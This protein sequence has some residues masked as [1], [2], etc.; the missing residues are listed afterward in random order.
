MHK[1]NDGL[2]LL[3]ILSAIQIPILHVIGQGGLLG[4]G[5]GHIDVIWFL[6][7]ASMCAV[8]CFAMLS[9]Y[10]D[11]GRHWRWS[12][13]LR[14]HL[15]V[16]FYTLSITAVFAWLRPE[17]VGISEWLAAL[18]PVYYYQYW[19]FTAYFGLFFLLPILSRGL[20]GLSR[21]QCGALAGTLVL[22]Y[23]LLPSAFKTDAFRT[24]KGYSFVWLLLLY[25]LGG[26]LRRLEPERTGSPWGFLALY[27]ISA[28]ATWALHRQLQAAGQKEYA[29]FLISY[30]S[31]GVL[32]CAT[33]LLLFCGRLSVGRAGAWFVRLFSPLSFSVY[34]IHTHPLI[35][36][37]VLKN[38]F[39]PY[40]DYAPG[41]LV[42]AIVGTALGIWL[43]CSLLD[44]IRLNLFRLL[45][46]SRLCEWA[47][48]KLPAFNYEETRPG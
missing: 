48:T 28:A 2:D 16:S 45:G 47:D 20:A 27:V 13:M 39:L 24:G 36:E 14:L 30:L 26:A 34:L 29:G 42:L 8:N 9:G 37:Y 41:R 6:E 43:G 18:F 12:S 38:R 5:S 35:W 21:S 31:P 22:L 15:T 44:L 19:Y 3:R 33:A 4:S 25:L 11:A 40:G 7:I 46:V 10:V 23:S 17:T 32:L 1:H